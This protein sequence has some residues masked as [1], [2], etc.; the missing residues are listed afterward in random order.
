MNATKSEAG[1]NA[2]PATFKVD[3]V[4]CSPTG[5]VRQVVEVVEGATIQQALQ[6]ARFRERFR[7]LNLEQSRVGIFGNLATLTTV[8]RPGDRVEVYRPI[9]CDP[10]TVPRRDRP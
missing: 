8:L 4:Y 1:A 9:T 10:E 7:N 5:T 3:V 6:R 2:A